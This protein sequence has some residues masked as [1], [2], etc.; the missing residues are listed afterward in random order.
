MYGFDEAKNKKTVIQPIMTTI[1]LDSSQWLY[2]EIVG[3]YAQSVN[4]TGVTENSAVIVAPNPAIGY[5][6]VYYWNESKIQCYDQ[7][8][9]V[10]KFTCDV[11]HIPTANISVN[12]LIMG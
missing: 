6:A 8:N 11:D 4:V 1:M 3:I 5:G 10:L 7:A 9:G 2:D 12:V